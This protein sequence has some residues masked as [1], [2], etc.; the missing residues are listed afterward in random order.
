M[1]VNAGTAVTGT[2]SVTMAAGSDAIV[3]TNDAATV[4]VV[5]GAAADTI[6]VNIN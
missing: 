2:M 3:N 6:T 1:T 5:A 4:S